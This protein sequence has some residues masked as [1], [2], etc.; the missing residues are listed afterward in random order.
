M[1]R[2]SDQ[3]AMTATDNVND[4]VSSEAER[5]LVLRPQLNLAMVW[6]VTEKNELNV[7][8][9]VGYEKSVFTTAYD[10]LY[11][12]PNS[13]LFYDL[14]INDFVINFHSSFSYS[15]DVT[16]DPTVNRSSGQT[17]FQNT[18]GVGVTWDLNKLVLMTTYDHDFYVPTDSQSS[19]Q[20]RSADLATLSAALRL[21]STLFAGLQLGGGMTHYDDPTQPDNQHIS[22]GPFVR[23][24][25][26]EYVSLRAAAGYVV[27]TLDTTA[28][29]DTSSHLDAFYFDVSL[30]QQL[31]KG[32]AHSLSVGRQIQSSIY[33]TTSEE[34]YARY[35]INWQ[36]FLKTGLHTYFSY[37]HIAE[38][39]GSD[40]IISYYNYTLSFDRQITRRISGSLSYQLYL[41]NSDVNSDDYTENRLVLTVIHAF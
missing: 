22:L 23:A 20:G 35:G 3:L 41:K 7:S 31:W 30:D 10:G 38:K 39:G 36:L 6:P 29:T 24:E 33:S 40:E 12:A 8:V 26:N 2:L 25:L 32:F 1:L 17:R 14:F 16:S 11:I 19:D 9:G 37:Q 13:D 21:R 27:Y 4:T 15:Q 18:S 28:D 5:D 34:Y